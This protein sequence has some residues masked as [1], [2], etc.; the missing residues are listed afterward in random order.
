[1]SRAGLRQCSGFGKI[2]LSSR[3]GRPSY[4]LAP[5]LCA[6]TDLPVAAKERKVG[7]TEEHRFRLATRDRFRESLTVPR[8]RFL[9]GKT[10]FLPM[11]DVGI[12]LCFICSAPSLRHL[13][14]ALEVV[15]P[16]VLIFV[17]GAAGSIL[18][19][20]ELIDKTLLGIIIAT[21]QVRSMSTECSHMVCPR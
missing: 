20:G 8:F 7:K 9:H 10:P 14:S 1:M 21:S 2:R 4:R 19:G 15:V 6:C 12:V 16:I 18:F 11:A 13:F 3:S 17:F 5:S